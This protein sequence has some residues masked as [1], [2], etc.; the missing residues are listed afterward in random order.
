METLGIFST[1]FQR[2]ATFVTSYW[3]NYQLSFYGKR[4]CS[5]RKEFSSQ[6]HNILFESRS[7]LIKEAKTFLTEL[8]PLQMYPFPLESLEEIVNERKWDFCEPQVIFTD[9]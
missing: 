9:S 5:K 4:V 2:E 7:L 6:E 1:I 8:P 3:L